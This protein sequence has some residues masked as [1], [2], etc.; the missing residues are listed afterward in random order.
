MDAVADSL[1]ILGA[2][3]NK[4]ICPKGP[5][6]QILRTPAEFLSC[7]LQLLEFLPVHSDS[8][9][10]VSIASWATAFTPTTWTAGRSECRSPFSTSHP[11]NQTISLEEYIY[12]Q[13]NQP[14]NSTKRL[15]WARVRQD[16][17]CLLGL[18]AASLLNTQLG[19]RAQEATLIPARHQW[20]A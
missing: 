2:G 5:D 4:T 11:R 13:R 1:L 20:P 7:W 8:Q 12:V 17:R 3:I 14:L 6:P 18:K 16:T 19:N 15:S 10:F 9:R